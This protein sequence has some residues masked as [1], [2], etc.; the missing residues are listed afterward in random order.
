MSLSSFR[1]YCNRLAP[2]ECDSRL[3][4]F[5][6]GGSEENRN[7]KL[8]MRRFKLNAEKKEEDSRVEA[9]VV[10]EIQ[11]SKIIM[12]RASCDEIFRRR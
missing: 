3:M 4:D 7:K 9:K 2:I 11:S 1:S 10:D 8:S 6:S 5:L 12:P